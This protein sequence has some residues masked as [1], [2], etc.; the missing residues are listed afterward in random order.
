LLFAYAFKLFVVLKEELVSNDPIVVDSV[1]NVRFCKL[2]DVEVKNALAGGKRKSQHFEVWALNAF[3]EWRICNGY[4]IE[5]SIVDLLEEPD[6]RK[7]V[8]LLLKFTCRSRKPMD[9][10]ICLSHTFLS[11][12]VFLYD[13]LIAVMYLFYFV[14]NFSIP[15]V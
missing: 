13:S 6:N 14:C 15:C 9:L 3:D 4:S 11:S 5:K 2:D 8:D 7:F 12:L 10:S 1:K